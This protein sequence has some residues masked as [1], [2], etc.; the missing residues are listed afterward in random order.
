MWASLCPSSQSLTQRGRASRT[1]SRHW[2]S[3]R[4]SLLTEP[5]PERWRS[6]R[7]FLSWSCLWSSSL[8]C[9]AS[10][11]SCIIEPT[12]PPCLT[13]SSG[14][15]ADWTSHTGPAQSTCLWSPEDVQ[16][17]RAPLGSQVY[18]KRRFHT[19][20]LDS[21]TRLGWS[22]GLGTCD[23]RTS[24]ELASP[25][26]VFSF[27]SLWTPQSVWACWPPSLGLLGLPQF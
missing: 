21:R 17:N 6:S 13:A 8:T 9:L 16:S 23:W 7:V 14:W 27:P 19:S 22:S 25:Q 1:P 26:F 4:L 3:R 2:C 18:P 10:P 20:L 15:S 5:G 24:S 12:Q 11:C